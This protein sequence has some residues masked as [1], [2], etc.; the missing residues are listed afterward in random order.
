MEKLKNWKDVKNILDKNFYFLN[1]ATHQDS[2]AMI[3]PIF[4]API[5]KNKPIMLNLN[6]W[7]QRE[8]DKS[9]KTIVFKGFKF[10]DNVELDLIHFHFLLEMRGPIDRDDIVS[11]VRD[12]HMDKRM[13]LIVKHPSFPGEA[14]CW[15][16]KQYIDFDFLPA[17]LQEVFI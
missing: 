2:A 12:N 6:D 15:F 17:E 8:V 7:L 13:Q 16:Y 3:I 14:K 9:L 11:K 1:R 4:T 10:L 5:C